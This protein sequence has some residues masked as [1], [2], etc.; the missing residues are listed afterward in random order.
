MGSA[1]NFFADFVR[2]EWETLV[3][4]ATEP[5]TKKQNAQED[6]LASMRTTDVGNN[7]RRFDGPPNEILMRDAQQRAVYGVATHGD[8]LAALYTDRMSGLRNRIHE[9]IWA[10]R[11]DSGA[12]RAFAQEML[13]RECKGDGRATCS[14][15]DG[16]GFFMARGEVPN[17]IPAASSF[18]PAK[19]P[20]HKKTAVLWKRL[21]DQSGNLD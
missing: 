12:W 7:L 4:F 19:E 16:R 10:M 8:S 21:V 15:C 13:C 11:E 1:E 9:R 17:P 14:T 5:D 18:T 6:I 2:T 3:S 20:T